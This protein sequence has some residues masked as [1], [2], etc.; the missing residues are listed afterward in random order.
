VAVDDRTN[1]LI[2]LG[3]PDALPTIEALLAK[4][5]QTASKEA[6]PQPQNVS[7]D[8]NHSLFLRLFWLAEGLPGNEGSD[9]ADVLPASVLRATK[10]LGLS[11]PRLVSQTVTSL[12]IQGI[13]SSEFTTIVP[14]QLKKHNAELNYDGQL[15]LISGQRAQITMDINVGGLGPS[16]MLKGSLVMPLG[17]YMVL[18]TANSMLPETAA[19]GNAGGQMR[20]GGGMPR[21]AAPGAYGGEFAGPEGMMGGEMG[22]G[23]AEAPQFSTLQFAFVVQVI[24]GESFAPEE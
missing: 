14:A 22:M 13:N 7:P 4:L 24:E 1:S 17:H 18:G 10:K 19:H 12:A 16:C 23:T 20:G 5:D 2:V 21:G 15:G 8:A 6:E 3:K 11:K 9:P